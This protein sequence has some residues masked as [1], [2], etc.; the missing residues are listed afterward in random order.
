ML[1]RA[2]AIVDGLVVYPERML[3][4]LARSRGL[5]SSEAV[6]LALIET[7]LGR[8]RAYEIVQGSAMRAYAGDG[9]FRALLAADP[10]VSSRLGTA[11]LARCFDLDHALR[12][13]DQ[14][15]ERAIRLSNAAR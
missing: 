3:A 13:A 9:D 11:D 12:F 7:G 14:L 10:E 8:Q 1:E 15:V 5:F 6:M 4:N 2:T